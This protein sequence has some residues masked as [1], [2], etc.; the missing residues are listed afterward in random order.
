LDEKGGKI[1][2]S[3]GNGLTIEEWLSYASPESLSQFMFQSPRSAKKL[4]FDV[5]PRNV[6][7]YLTYLD[8][9][10][11]QE[12][13]D[14]LQNPVWHIHSGNPPPVER[15]GSENVQL[16]FSMLL[17]IASVSNAETEDQMWGFIRQYAPDVGRATHPRL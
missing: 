4:H 7:D 6:D 12:L 16:S 17:N 3:K 5:I 11:Q 15:I 13:K 10:P 9:F 1:S 14:R 8:L 2:K